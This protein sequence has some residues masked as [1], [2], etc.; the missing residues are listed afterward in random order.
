[1]VVVVNKAADRFMLWLAIAAGLGL[2][3]H[4]FARRAAVRGLLAAGVASAVANGPVK[5]MARRPG[6]RLSS[7][8]ARIPGLPT[9]RTSSFPSSHS[10]AAF[11]FAA[12]AGQEMPSLAVPLGGLAV[13]VGYSR[14][15]AGVHYPSDVLAGSAI[16][17]GVGL[18]TRRLWPI[19]PQDPA[20]AGDAAPKRSRVEPSD[21]GEGIVV[22]V[23]PSAGGGSAADAVE[24]LTEILPAVK[25]VEVAD[26][27]ELEPVLA[28]EAETARA[29]GVAGGDGSINV[30]A[31]VAAE[32]GIPLLVV[33]GGTLNHFALAVGVESAS[34]A[35]Q[36]VRA[37]QVVEVDRA[38][39]A[40]KTFVNTASIGSYVE[41][42]DAREQLEDRIGKWPAVVVALWRLLR[43][44]TPVEIEIDGRPLRTWMVFIGN[45]R[46][47][48]H[49]F[50]PSWRECLHDGLLDVRT[51][52]AGH[53]L[54]RTRLVLAVLTGRLGRC[55]VYE[56]YRVRQ[57]KVR[58]LQGPL[59][60]A[61]D[62]E[63]FDGPEAFTV[64]KATEP[65]RVYVP[66]R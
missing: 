47:H 23:N 30:G 16:G 3:R 11:A 40:G 42:V 26:G 35:A 9:I 64:E 24:Q 52:R 48:P 10:A 36:A 13:L 46:Y 19:A 18:A 34:D 20:D 41:L 12:G 58:S 38:L 1:L 50:A 2:T 44:A 32:H 49:G 54:A 39:I 29:I 25:V 55:G 66:E 45:C 59:R 22:V 60:L 43:R 4:R 51:V 6:P 62:G 65:L 61:R 63:T 14:V 5:L 56:E 31:S 7:V 57:M 28:K 8:S 27:S 37:G 17:V 15:H 21:R 53:P 33:P